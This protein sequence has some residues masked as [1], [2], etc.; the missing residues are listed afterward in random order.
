MAAARRQAAVL[1]LV[2]ALVMGAGWAPGPRGCAA[3]GEAVVV[4]SYGEGRLSLK[5]YDWTYLRGEIVSVLCDLGFGSFLR[6]PVLLR[7]NFVSFL[8]FVGCR[9]M[10]VFRKKVYF[11]PFSDGGFYGTGGIGTVTAVLRFSLFTLI[12]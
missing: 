4:A 11:T 8:P 3:Q 5:P 6:S 7:Q 9:W 10:L 1:V 2:L 12:F